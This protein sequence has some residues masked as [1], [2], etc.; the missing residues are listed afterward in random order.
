MALPMI[1]ILAL[2]M[3]GSMRPPENNP[4]TTSYTIET[5]ELTTTTT[6]ETTKTEPKSPEFYENNEMVVYLKENIN[7]NMSL[8][9]IVNVVDEAC[10]ETRDKD[11]YTLEYGTKEYKT[12]D[13]SSGEY[14]SRGQYYCF[15]IERWFRAE[16]G[17]SYK[18]CL[19]V[20]YEVNDQNKDFQNARMYP[21]DVSKDFPDFFDYI[22]KS[23]AFDYAK[24][25]KIAGID[26]YMA[27]D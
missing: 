10:K 23:Y 24:N 2:V 14:V 8:L 20:L 27:P 1:F 9:E 18:I 11:S 22:R 19:S 21:G 26:I 13:P 3:F 15:C 7:E 25:E 16:D 5:T 4:A 12:Y 17:S 6:T